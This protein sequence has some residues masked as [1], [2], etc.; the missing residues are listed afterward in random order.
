MS[1]QYIFRESQHSRR[2]GAR[3]SGLA[4]GFAAVF[5]LVFLLV[6]SMAHAQQPVV[7]VNFVGGYGG[8]TPA[9]MDATETAGVLPVANWNQAV[10]N[11]GSQSTLADSAGA[12]TAFSVAWT[13]PNTWANGAT[14]T[15]GNI[16]MFKGYL[17]TGG[18]G[19][20]PAATSFTVSGLDA[21][22]TYSVY[23][24][25]SGGNTG[26][27]GIYSIGSQTFYLADNGVAD[28]SSFTQATSTSAATPTVANYIIFTVAGQTT[29]TLTSTPDSVGGGGFRSPINGFQIQKFVVP[30]AAPTGLTTTAAD[31]SLTLNWN[32]VA[33]AS[34]YNVLR[35]TKAGG[36]YTS[37]AAGVATSTYTDNAVVNG[38]TYYYVVQAV[39]KNGTSGNSNEASGVPVAAIIGSGTLSINFVGGGGAV[40][41]S[42]M[43]PTEIAGVIPV[44]NWNNFIGANGGL[45]LTD[46][47]GAA[48]SASISVSG[49]PNTWSSGVPDNPGNQRMMVGYLDSGNA[50]V[51]SVALSG[52]SPSKTYLIYVYTARDDTNS[53][54]L[55][56]VG[57]QTFAAQPGIFGGTFTQVTA[58]DPTK[59]MAGN[60]MV[61]QVT[62]S[63]SYTVMATPD[64]ATNG[65][66]APVNAVQVI[67]LTAPTAPTGLAAV[68]LDSS[69]YLTWNAVPVATTYNILRA[70]KAGG[71]YTSVATGVAGTT[72]TDTAL[73][74]GTTYYYVVRGVNSIGTSPNS[75]EAS[76]KP[77]AAVLGTGNGLYGV[78][79]TPGTMD[80]SAETTGTVVLS[81][82]VPF[83]NYNQ[84]NANVA[85]N[86][87]PWP[88]GIPT[89]QF[90]A[91][92]TGQVL[93]PYT[94]S[95]QFQ[96]VTDDG[97]RL[98]IDSDTA[99][100]TVLFD[101]ELGHGPLANTGA[102]VTLT[103]GKKYNIKFEFTQQGGGRTAQLLY[104]PLGSAFQIIPQS[105]LFTVFTQAPDA[106]INL[107]AVGHNK[108]VQLYWNGG[109]NT[110]TFN[111]KRS[112]TAGGPYTT[113]ATG[114]TTPFYLDS[115]LNNG[116]TYYYVVSATNNIGTSGNSNQASAL[117]TGVTS[118]VAYWRFEGGVAGAAVVPLAQI[119]DATGHNNTL[120]TP[121]VGAAP[122][123]A[124]SVFGNPTNPAA[125]NVLSLDF[126]AAPVAPYT[127]RYLDTTGATGDINSHAFNQFT[128]EASFKLNSVGTTQTLVGK[129]GFAFL[130]D[131]NPSN[132]TL[133][134]QVTAGNAIS[135]QAHQGDQTFIQAFGTTT[136]APNQW[137]N[138]VA[139]S[140]GFYVTLY[141]QTQGGAY[142]LES[143]TQFVGPLYDGQGLPFSIGRGLF[144]NAASDRVLGLIDE[145][146]VSDVA[147]DPSL[148]LFAAPAGTTVTGNIALEG[149]NDLSATSAAAPLGTFDIQF[150]TPGTLTVVKEFPAVT[151]T[152]TTGSANGKFSV[153]GLTAGTYDVWIKGAKNLA[154]LNPNVVV[155]GS[156]V[157]VPDSL[158]GAGDSDNNNTVDV[159][160]FGNLV[161]AYGSKASDPN[162]GYDPTVDFD[163]NGA[164]DVLDFGDLV[165][166]YGVSGPK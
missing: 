68:G 23:V 111:V 12:P 93:A 84:G 55:Y 33:G 9:N 54:A 26:R 121:D 32:A 138:A 157:A 137:Y 62:G 46:S 86:P 70:T 119:A 72:F 145:V 8:N 95:Y 2:N 30:P 123:Y 106:P 104:S 118:P 153:S 41:P 162:S 57:A 87:L 44:A 74:N 89:T 43:G 102:A 83:I 96:T 29:F 81:N 166:E 52:L 163:F 85:N 133:Y 132:S 28:G 161:N 120:Q 107:L 88:S 126:S 98:T 94:G 39:N 144:N 99:S 113:V 101:D 59:P 149:V 148:F 79:Y 116:T 45:A 64:A 128:I 40:T 103:A 67:V 35:A 6:G 25:A 66:R 80:F 82:V 105:Q 108:S 76:A 58:T 142:N 129:D 100:G 140:D 19:S 109:L 130:G 47:L 37:I 7:S 115:G 160:D 151:L 69:V 152:K 50:T 10:G 63:G 3:A 15:P 77:V 139:V 61:F 78:Y 18:N 13:S 38:T 97:A 110:A 75:N 150:R 124:A 21:A 127:L 155:S 112:L 16:R 165:N 125:N 154:V 51:T 134:F 31:S 53:A 4:A 147:L 156:T 131:P 114:V 5:G 42:P 22:S 17:D 48:T 24:Y 11:T 117:T 71:P 65:F 91:V 1:K 27:S 159:L 136:I 60:Y 141:L 14:D 135:L 49:V 143:V 56:S 146:R 20:A 73:T 158:L 36:P 164:V 122:S 90:T 92:W 34:T